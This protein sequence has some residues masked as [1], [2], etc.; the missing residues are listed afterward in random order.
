MSAQWVIAYRLPRALNLNLTLTLTLILNLTLC[1][2]LSP[3][4]TLFVALALTPP[5]ADHVALLHLEHHRSCDYA[6]QVTQGQDQG[7][8][9]DQDQ[10]QG[11]GQGQDQ[12]QAADTIGF[13]ATVRHTLQLQ[14]HTH[15]RP[16]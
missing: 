8:G 4:L 2:T 1:L 12:Y 3:T 6:A 14:S 7:Q 13:I 9:Q 16:T 5:T 15:K 10:S 11:Q